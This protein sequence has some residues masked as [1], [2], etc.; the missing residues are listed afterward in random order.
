MLKLAFKIKTESWLWPEYEGVHVD[1][2]HV[3]LLPPE[4]DAA[5]PIG[6]A[7]VGVLDE[8][9]SVRLGDLLVTF[10]CLHLRPVRQTSQPS[11]HYNIQSPKSNLNIVISY[12]YNFLSPFVF[13]IGDKMFP[14]ILVGLVIASITLLELYLRTA[15]SCWA[16]GE[17]GW[18]NCIVYII[19]YG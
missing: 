8:A 17:E 12:Y 7:H 2:D 14:N 5:G 1:Q 19:Y 13:L 10:E 6:V 11:W 15:A 18:L 16:R 9:L 3:P 4:D